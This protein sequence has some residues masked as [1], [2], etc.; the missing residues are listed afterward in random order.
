MFGSPELCLQSMFGGRVAG[1]LQIPTLNKQDH[2]GSPIT[3]EHLMVRLGGRSHFLRFQRVTQIIQ[4]I[5]C[6]SSLKVPFARR[7]IE[8]IPKLTPR[9]VKKFER[10]TNL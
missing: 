6:I 8:V 1:P 2:R 10:W 9:V 7:R 3:Q 5:R 4:E